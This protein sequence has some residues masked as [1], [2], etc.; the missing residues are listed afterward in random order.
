MLTRKISQHKQI[1]DKHDSDVEHL[2][3]VI[4]AARENFKEAL[5]NVQADYVTKSDDLLKKVSLLFILKKIHI[6]C[7][8]MYDIYNTTKNIRHIFVTCMLHGHKLGAR[9][10]S[11]SLVVLFL[12]RRICVCVCVCVCV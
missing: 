1:R 12:I 8:N 10:L 5:I 7:I 11:F 2:K 6:G 9:A 3:T 4:F